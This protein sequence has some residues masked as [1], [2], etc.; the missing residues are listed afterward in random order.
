MTQSAQSTVP[1]LWQRHHTCPEGSTVVHS[2]IGMCSVTEKLKTDGTDDVCQWTSSFEMRAHQEVR[3]ICRRHLVKRI[4]VPHEL[5]G[6]G[7][8]FSGEQE[9]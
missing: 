2:C 3:N 4:Q 5:L 9:W 6:R 1:V 7:P 8:S